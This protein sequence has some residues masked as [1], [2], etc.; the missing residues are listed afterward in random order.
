MI[1]LRDQFLDYLSVER[2]LS[3]NTIVSYGRDLGRFISYLESRHIGSLDKVTRTEIGDFLLRLKDNNL[4]AGSISRN[5]VAIKVFFRFLV[6]ERLLKDDP[7]AIIDSPKLWKHLPDVLTIEEVEDLIAQP[8]PNSWMGIRDKAILE[9]LY[10][11]GMRV[12]ELAQLDLKDLNLDS[13]FIRCIGKGNKERVVP[14]GKKAV[15]SLQSYLEKIRP[16]LLKEKTNNKLFL[17]KFTTKISRQS[18]WKI[19]KRYARTA[20]IKK[21]I[22]PHTLRHSFAT[23]L[24]QRGAD[25]RI[26]QEFLGHANI[27]TTQIYTH[28]NRDRLKSIHK[29]FHPRP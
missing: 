25:L 4:S 9:L 8:K 1:K 29:Q 24:L 2:G 14:I 13:G 12:S 15:K 27:S 22:T 11:T 6:S 17:T 19:I 16:K 23:H 10:A 18:L 7:S 28:I 20:G 21:R 3:K 26:V 5:L